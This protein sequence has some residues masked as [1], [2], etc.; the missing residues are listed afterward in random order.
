MGADTCVY[1]DSLPLRINRWIESMY[2]LE[3]NTVVKVVGELPEAFRKGGRQFKGQGRDEGEVVVFGCGSMLSTS[4]KGCM[5]GKT[6]LQRL[7]ERHGL[8]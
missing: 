1:D 2:D 4:N 5:K 7:P 8:Q 3:A 6:D